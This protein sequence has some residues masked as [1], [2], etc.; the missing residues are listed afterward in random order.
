MTDAQLATKRQRLVAI[1]LMVTAVTC[2]SFLDTTAKY[3]RLTLPVVEVVWARYF[4]AVLVTLVLSNPISHPGL[5]R[6][7]RPW[8][9]IFRSSLLV[10][11]TLLAFIALRYLQLDEQISI[12]FVA[13]FLIAALSGPILG[14]WISWQRWAAICTAFIGVL[15]VTRPFAGGI[16]P[17]ALLTCC[18]VVC[19]ALYIIFTRILARTDSS[20]TTLFYSN[21]VGAA[22]MSAVVPFVWVT[23]DNLFTVLIMLLCGTF[24]SVGHYLLIMAHR[25]A[26]AA[27]LSPYIYT[28][29][30][31]MVALGY[32]IFGDVPNRWTLIGAAVVI[33]SGLYLLMLE[34]HLSRT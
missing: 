25:Y 28:Q 20:E 17:A 12:V 29:L 13:P 2:F 4:G 5:L 27:V 8:L 34:R 30:L 26:P 15:I 16:H 3:L 1:G 23:P 33:A 31:S 6:T 32:L 9:Q 14:E 21:V 19:Y 11:S 24:G 18:G 10:V 7:S 22:V